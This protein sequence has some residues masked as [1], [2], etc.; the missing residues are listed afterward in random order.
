M[1]IPLLVI[2]YHF[3]F[4]AHVDLNSK[5]VID[6]HLIPTQGITILHWIFDVSV[7]IGEDMEK[8]N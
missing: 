8:S 2:R 1:F 7:T 3:L 6:S 5:I 4:A